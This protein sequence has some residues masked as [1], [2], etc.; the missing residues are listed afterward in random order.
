MEL[1]FIFFFFPEKKT[2]LCVVQMSKMLLMCKIEGSS[3]CSGQ[4][5]VKNL[6]LLL[7]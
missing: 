4:T 6:P 7:V 2:N 3:R 1:T 5:K